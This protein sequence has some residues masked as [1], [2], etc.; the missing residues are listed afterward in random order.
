M[1][2]EKADSNKKC[3]H[4]PCK[5]QISTPAQYCSDYCSEAGKKAKTETKCSCGHS[6]CK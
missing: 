6:S 3:A 5:C 1:N 4:G 2:P